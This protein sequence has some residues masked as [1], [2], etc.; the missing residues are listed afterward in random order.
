[1]QAIT[2]EG[3]SDEMAAP[4]GGKLRLLCLHGYMQ[5]GGV[6]RMRIGS[7]RKALKSRADFAFIDAPY[8]A[9]QPDGE[10]SD[11]APGGRAWWTWADTGSDARPSRAATYSG[12]P[13]AYDAIAAA[14]AEHKPH[15]LLGFSQARVRAPADRC[16]GGCGPSAADA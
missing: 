12:W 2:G 6:F 3:E 1:L 8:P 7:W 4:E 10:A 11:E 15:G 9:A 5:T 16:A 13:L 14:V